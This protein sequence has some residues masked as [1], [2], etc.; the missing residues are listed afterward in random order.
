[1]GY[2]YHFLTRAT[3]LEAGLVLFA[4]ILSLVL[5]VVGIWIAFYAKG[6]AVLGI[7]GLFAFVPL[8]LCLF[9]ILAQW[10]HN[11]A[12]YATAENSS[13]YYAS[14]RANYIV[15]AGIGI[16]LTALPVLIGTFGLFRPRPRS[17]S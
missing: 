10:L 3:L 1:M 9:G 12:F 4:V 2:L 8:V 6:R 5:V 14:D 15:G 16:G 7:Y 11:R 17:Q 13:M